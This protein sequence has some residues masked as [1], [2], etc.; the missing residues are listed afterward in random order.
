MSSIICHYLE[1]AQWGKGLA[2]SIDFESQIRIHKIFIPD[3]SDEVVSCFELLDADE[4]KRA[5]NYLQTKDS[6]RFIIARGM[7]KRIAGEYL[8]VPAT[9]VKIKVGPNKKPFIFSNANLA[10]DYNISHSGNWIVMAFGKGSLGIDVEQIQ[11]SFNYES[12]LPACFSMKEQDF[13]LNNPMSR[14]LFYRLWTRKESFV[15]AT[16]KGLDDTLPLL[17]CL[18]GQWELQDQFSNGQDWET[19]SF[20]LDQ[21]HVVSVS[22][23]VSKKNIL[24]IEQ[25]ME[26]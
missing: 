3:N 1:Q 18:D 16:S 12:L 8:G 25:D 2:V 24:F 19:W 7:L 13:I 22:F 6:Q 11:T 26:N 5:N 15:K 4:K 9:E 23:V 17:I 14:E 21:E 20:P 10:L